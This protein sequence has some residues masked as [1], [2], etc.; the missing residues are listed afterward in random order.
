MDLRC[1]FL[2]VSNGNPSSRLKRIWC[3][4][5][6]IVPVP[7]RSSFSVPSSS[8]L[9]SKSR[10]CFILYVILVV[11]LPD[12]CGQPV[13]GSY[14]KQYDATHIQQAGESHDP[15]HDNESHSP[16]GISHGGLPA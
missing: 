13:A 7:V 8:I 1:S 3:P 9:C 2:V 15:F 4:K 14:A 10:Y 6:L 5:I 12:E 11:F 16:A